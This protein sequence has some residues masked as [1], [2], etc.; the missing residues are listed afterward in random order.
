MSND[1]NPKTSDELARELERANE[2]AAIAD[3]N[4]AEQA[5]MFEAALEQGIRDVN[6]LCKIMEDDDVLHFEMDY[7]HGQ[8][9]VEVRQP[10]ARPNVRHI[11]IV[12]PSANAH[13]I[14]RILKG[15]DATEA[16]STIMRALERWSIDSEGP[17][18]SLLRGA[19]AMLE[20]KISERQR[21]I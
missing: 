2:R 20:R 5:A 7:L 11:D 8:L 14:A 15:A 3:E 12:H 13:E 16:A 10:S 18:E 17:G 1:D 9:H 4:L 6:S 21:G 19:L